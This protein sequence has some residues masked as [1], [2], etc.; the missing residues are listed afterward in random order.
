ME[1]AIFRLFYTVLRILEKNDVDKRGPEDAIIDIIDFF[2]E[3]M[4]PTQKDIMLKEFM[5]YE[6][7]RRNRLH[8]I[9]RKKLIEEEAYRDLLNRYIYGEDITEKK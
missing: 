6:E 1:D 8:D 3:H 4:L 5:R 7:R 9:Q 2:D